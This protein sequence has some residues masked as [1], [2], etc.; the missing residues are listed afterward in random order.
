MIPY[1]LCIES[2]T[3][4]CSVALLHGAEVVASRESV[5]GNHNANLSIF[6]SEL[7][8]LIPDER[9]LDAIAVG[10]GPGS[11]TGLRIS[12]SLAKGLAFSLNIPLISVSSL[13]ILSESIRKEHPDL[14]KGYAI[15]PMLDARRMEVYSAVYT[16]HEEGTSKSFVMDREEDINKFQRLVAGSSVIL[17]GGDGAG[18]IYPLFNNLFGSKAI[19]VEA[20]RLHA[21]SM[22]PIVMK[23]WEEKCFVDLA[24][25]TPDYLKEYAAV[26]TSNKVIGTKPNSLSSDA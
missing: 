6:A 4:R 5:D 7:M 10:D 1:I 8:A 21:E 11:Y 19:Y 25:W 18:K 16:E 15:V 12:A 24:Y 17:Y 23:S 9:R 26:I 3:K 14:P 20:A 2:A 22:A 13:K